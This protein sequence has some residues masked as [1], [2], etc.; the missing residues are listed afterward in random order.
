[1]ILYILLVIELI[2]IKLF[3]LYNIYLYPEIALVLIVFLFTKK[4]DYLKKVFIL[5]I[6]YDL[7]YSNIF[8]YNALIFL[9]LGKINK[10]IFNV[11]KENNFIKIIVLIIN[12]IIYDIINYS[13]I[14][15]SKYQVLSINN[16]LDKISRSIIINILSLL[17]LLILFKKDKKKNKINW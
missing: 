10:K 6:I 12:I 13:V 15:I 3:N 8:M 17:V 5:G 4:K 2:I 11:L 14:I 9:L 16:L 7:L 1:M